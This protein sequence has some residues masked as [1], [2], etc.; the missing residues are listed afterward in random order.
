MYPSMVNYTNDLHKLSGTKELT[1]RIKI[2]GQVISEYPSTY[3]HI[4][5]STLRARLKTIDSIR[6]LISGWVF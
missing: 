6:V 2:T 3:L 1:R 4:A 5:S